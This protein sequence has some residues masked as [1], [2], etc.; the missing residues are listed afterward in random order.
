[1]FPVK[2]GTEPPWVKCDFVYLKVKQFIIKKLLQASLQREIEREETKESAS[3][4]PQFYCGASPKC[5]PYTL[6]G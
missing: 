3:A 5:M 2:F 6:M 4:A 1:M